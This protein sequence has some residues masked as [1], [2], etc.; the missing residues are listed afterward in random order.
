MIYLD[1]GK[2]EPTVKY[3]HALFLN[4]Y[5]ESSSTSVMGLFPPTGLEY[6]ATSAKNYVQKLTLL[7]LRYEK[8][9]AGTDNLLNFIHKDKVDILCISIAWDRQ[10]Q[11][12]KSLLNSMPDEIPLVVGGYKATEQAEELLQAC[13]K[14]DIIVR[15]EGEETVKDI[16]KGLPL[17]DILGISYRVNGGIRHNVNRPLG[18]VDDI[19]YPDR[20]L[21]RAKYRITLNGISLTDVSFDT[22]L[23]ARGCPNNCKFCTFKLNPLGQKRNYSMRR[24][25][26]VV[27]EIENLDAEAILFSDDNFFS[28]V[29]RAERICDLLIERKVKKHFFAQARIE[30]AD[31]PHLLEKIVKA[32]FKLLLLGIES[33]HDHILAQLNKGFDSSS[34]RRSFNVLRKYPIYYHGYFIYGNINET[35][36]EM[37]YI[38]RFAK[39]IGVD[40]ITFQK[41]RIERFSGLKDLAE[42]TPGYHVTDRGELYSDKYSHA[43][44]KKI[45]RSIKFSFYTPFRLM[46]IVKKALLVNLFSFREIVSFLILS[47]VFLKGLISR[48][49]EKKRLK[50]SLRRIFIRNNV[51]SIIGGEILNGQE[52]QGLQ[53]RKGL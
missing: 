31:H 16:M 23:S 10:F 25:E 35:E 19:S 29:K 33:P 20:S 30:I 12:I 27:S 32:G 21:R 2:R 43:A 26:S 47:P 18:P 42:S 9:L 36:N 15:G 34:I 51:K 17:K 50:D 13:P 7:D 22:V 44:L 45:G 3:K 11:E 5:I 53:K 49:M 24:V 41:L 8:E 28:N 40:S 38:P 48:E 39:E 37:L 4:P 6:V 46:K 52:N 1:T 14:I